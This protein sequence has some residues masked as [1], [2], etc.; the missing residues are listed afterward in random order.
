MNT[1]RFACLLAALGSGLFPLGGAAAP[2]TAADLL[3]P[4]QAGRLGMVESWRRQLSA[5]AGSQSLVDISLHVEGARTRTFVEVKTGEGDASEILLRI[6]TDQVD[7]FGNPIGLE[8]AERR[9]K[10]EV[11]RLRHRGIEARVDKATFPQVR[12]YTLGNDG[13]VEARDAETGELFWV[14]RHGNSR[15]PYGSLG[16]SD[17]Y[18]SFINGSQVFQL[19]TDDGKVVNQFPL[20]GSSLAGCAIAGDYVLVPTTRAGVEGFPLTETDR[21]PFLEYTAGRATAEPQA[22]PGSSLAAWGTDAGLVYVMDTYG[23]PSLLFRFDCDGVVLAQVAAAAGDRFFFGTDSGLVYGLKATRTGE[24]LWR[25]S[26]DQPVDDAVFL[27]GDRL[28]VSTFYN[29][30]FCLELVGGEAHWAAPASRV[31]SVLAA[32]DDQLF[33]RTNTQQLGVLTKATGAQVSSAPITI[34]DRFVANRQTDRLYLLGVGGTLQCLRPVGS[35][36]PKIK[37]A[38]KPPPE[39]DAREEPAPAA[40]AEPT[41][42]DPAA[43]PTDDSDPFGPAD[44]D[45]FGDEGFGDVFGGEDPF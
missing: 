30:L 25:T 5:I 27:D 34:G 28:Y 15:L 29:N 20:A 36:M 19:S 3:S 6:P 9:G 41:P 22:S 39:S 13:T 18:V 1:I 43:P 33:V 42:P 44:S 4:T 45:P 24:V 11:L 37:T 10:M 35:D 21:Y 17:D 40:P 14:V 12:I 38:I 23:K 26:L 16:V 8:E 2:A 7:T 31:S 32:T